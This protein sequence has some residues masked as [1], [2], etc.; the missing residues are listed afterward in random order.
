MYKTTLENLIA[1]TSTNFNTFA[2]MVGESR[3]AL[4]S[5]LKSK[6]HL[7]FA[8]KYAVKLG[9]SKLYGV[10]NGCIVEVIIKKL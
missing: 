3:Q 6:N 4:R 9:L 8:Y 2:D 7:Q 10:E 5:Q 1:D